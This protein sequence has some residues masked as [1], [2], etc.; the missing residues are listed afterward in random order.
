[1][2]TKTEVANLISSNSQTY[3][4]IRSPIVIKH[5]TGNIQVSLGYDTT[6]LNGSMNVLNDISGGDIYATS[7]QGDALISTNNLITQ[8]ATTQEALF[9]VIT[10]LSTIVNNGITEIN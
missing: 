9:D 3:R 7:I 10:P 4:D 1:M 6:T 2:Y 5:S 8:R